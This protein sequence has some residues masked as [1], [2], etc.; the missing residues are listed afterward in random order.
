MGLLEE[1]PAP[2]LD[3]PLAFEGA[4]RGCIPEAPDGGEDLADP[5]LRHR[6]PRPSGRAG[7]VTV[8]PQVWPGRTAVSHGPF[9]PDSPG[10]W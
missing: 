10:W 6:C 3:R 1:G 5:R 2:G 7:R 8:R 4:T 9:V